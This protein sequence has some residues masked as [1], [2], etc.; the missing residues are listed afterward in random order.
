MVV[1]IDEV[2]RGSLAGP[3]VIGAVSLS[4]P[5]HQLKDSKQL[6]GLEREKIA[7]EIYINANYTSLGWVWPH[8]IDQLG[9]TG[10]TSLAISRALSVNKHSVDLIQLDGNYNFVNNHIPVQLIVNGDKL[11]PAISAASIIAK[12]ARDNFMKLINQYFPEYG[13]SNHVGYGT[14]QHL[15][16]ISAFG[17]CVLHRLSFSPLA[18]QRSTV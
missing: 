2:G 6:N 10:A 15:A 7:K 11:I 14:K 17:P 3:L 16:A 12:V 13:F 9:L 4:R 1:G 18:G 5:I 8:E